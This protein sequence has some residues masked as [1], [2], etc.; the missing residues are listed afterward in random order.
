MVDFETLDQFRDLFGVG[1]QGRH[2]DD[3]RNAEGTP[4]FN[5][6][7]GKVGRERAR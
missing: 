6:R 7:P 2:G 5:S 4:S 1:E 3:V